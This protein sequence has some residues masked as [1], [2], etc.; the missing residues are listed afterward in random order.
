MSPPQWQCSKCGKG[1]TDE[2]LPIK[3]ER[4]ISTL[5]LDHDIHYSQ[6]PHEHFLGTLLLALDILGPRQ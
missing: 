5:V 6:Y 3:E 4:W 1:F 2:D